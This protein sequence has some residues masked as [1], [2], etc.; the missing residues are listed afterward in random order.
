MAW[1]GSEG[2]DLRGRPNGKEERYELTDYVFF[3]SFTPTEYKQSGN[4]HIW[5]TFH[6]DGNISSDEGGRCTP[7]PF[8]ISTITYKDVVYAPAERAATLALFLLYPFKYSV[9]TS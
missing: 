5:F 1:K 2:K 6:H 8:T 9:F 4:G 3:S 7:T